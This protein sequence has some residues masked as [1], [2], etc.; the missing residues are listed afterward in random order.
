[1]TWRQYA[2]NFDNPINPEYE[3]E[4]RLVE[5]SRAG[6]ERAFSALLARYQQPVFRLI[7]YL[8]GD[9]EEA[10][11]LT[12]IAIKNALLHMPSVPAG[13][14]IRPWL[15]RVAVLVALDAVRERS[16]TPQQLLASLQLPAPAA[17]P[18]IVDADPSDTDTMELGITRMETLANRPETAIADAWDTLPV[19]VE[20]ELIRRLLSGLPEGDAELLAL[21]V[22]GQ[23]PTRDLAALAGTS[24]RSIRRRIA[25][26]LILFQSRYY[27]VRNDAL[28]PASQEKALPLSEGATSPIDLARRGI[29]EAGDRVMR[30]LQGVRTGF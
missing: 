11:D 9:D 21:G 16:E 27:T 24:Q 8:V 17:P 5:Q 13:F 30:T 25:R 3:Q 22:V 2:G 20:R 19:D 6:S 14:S 18:R 4:A 29:N 1:M 23:I 10:R 15:L 28:P 12:R 26:A 7:F